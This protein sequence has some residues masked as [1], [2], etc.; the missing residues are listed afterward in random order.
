[1]RG[2]HT[3]TAVSIEHLPAEQDGM[4]YYGTDPVANVRLVGEVLFRSGWTRKIMPIETLKGPLGDV[5]RPE[6]TK[7]LEQKSP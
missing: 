2:D 7:R 6:D 3:I 5:L 1:M 4:R